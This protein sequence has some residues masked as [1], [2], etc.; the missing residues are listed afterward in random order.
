MTV[1]TVY[2]FS[3]TSLQLSDDCIDSVAGSLDESPLVIKNTLLLIIPAVLGCMASKASK[4]TAEAAFVHT[5]TKR[6]FL[7]GLPDINSVLTDGNGL[8]LN[9]GGDLLIKMAG[10]N[11]NTVLKTV[12]AASPLP[13]HTVCTLFCLVLMMLAAITG[14]AAAHFNLS[15][16]ELAVEL[17]S[18]VKFTNLTKSARWFDNTF[19]H[20]PE[21]PVR[22]VPAPGSNK[23]FVIPP[24]IKKLFGKILLKE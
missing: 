7:D 13:F 24:L 11:H 2:I 14:K 1:F 22:P 5:E 3:Q 16:D 6:L 23:R 17:Q 18:A 20:V 19:F 10:Q 4:G 12:A 15:S 21:A 8:L 9:Q